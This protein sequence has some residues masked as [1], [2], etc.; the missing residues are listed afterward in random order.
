[1]GQ[2]TAGV[3]LTTR[4]LKLPSSQTTTLQLSNSSSHQLPSATNARIP[5]SATPHLWPLAWWED[6]TADM[7]VTR[8]CPR[9]QLPNSLAPQ[10]HGCI[11]VWVYVSGCVRDDI[12]VH[13]YICVYACMHVYVCI[14]VGV[15]ISAWLCVCVC[16]S[17]C[18]C[19][20]MYVCLSICV[21]VRLYVWLDACQFACVYVCM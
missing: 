4:L 21:Y 11:H 19:V 13:M 7:S 18:M 6:D 2:S 10:L 16:V 1:M 15:C 9:P 3:S 14:Y 5:G 17:V 20:G 8:H 12:C